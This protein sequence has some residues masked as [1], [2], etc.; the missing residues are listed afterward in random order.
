MPRRLGPIA[1]AFLHIHN[2][3]GNAGGTEGE[4]SAP[5]GSESHLP[6][7]GAKETQAPHY[8]HEIGAI[9]QSERAFSHA[10]TIR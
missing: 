5:G 8:P 10:N 6:A 3:A 4:A 9:T 2:T 1:C 7:R